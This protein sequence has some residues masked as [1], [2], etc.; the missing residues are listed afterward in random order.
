MPTEPRELQSARQ[1]L[2]LAESGF[3]SKDGLFHLDEALSLLE[4]VI[5]GDSTAHT[6]IARN[7]ASTYA[8][9][10]HRAVQ[11]LL[12]MDHGIP[13]PE[14]EHLFRIVL[15]FDQR[16]FELP[17][18]SRA[19]KNELVRQLIDRY[20]EGRSPAEKQAMLEELTRIERSQDA[21]DRTGN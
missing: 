20:Y 3:R 17:A 14:L 15:L 13:E 1:H 5:A 2:A 8:T 10:I 9:R 7:L 16:N 6:R 12:Q 19:N 18:E 11:R 4:D 21:A